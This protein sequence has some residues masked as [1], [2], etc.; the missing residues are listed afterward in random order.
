MPEELAL[1]YTFR[2]SFGKLYV[3]IGDL[4]IDATVPFENR[5]DKTSLRQL[6]DEVCDNAPHRD[7][8]GPEQ[9]LLD[10]SPLIR[11]SPNHVQAELREVLTCLVKAVERYYEFQS[12]SSTTTTK[13]RQKV[14]GPKSSQPQSL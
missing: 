4:F 5:H 11:N 10:I 3:T 8:L 12:T 2:L 9:F 6:V 1:K 7:W 14:L 13:K